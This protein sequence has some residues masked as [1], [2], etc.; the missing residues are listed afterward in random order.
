[1][2]KL[3]TLLM[4]A[5]LV[6]FWW[7]G[8]Q[9]RR[10][11]TMPLTEARELLGLRADAGSDEIRDAHRRIIARVHPDAGGTIEL[12]RRTNLARD[13]LLRELAATHRD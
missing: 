2:G 13:V 4:L 10:R 3:L 7:R 8:N 9:Q 6:V 11:T 1:M 5:A 12:A